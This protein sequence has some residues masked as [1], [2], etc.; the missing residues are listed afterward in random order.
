MNEHTPENDATLTER[1]REGLIEAIQ[2]G[3]EVEFVESLIATRLARFI[4]PGLTDH[5]V[6]RGQSS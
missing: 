3:N 2:A 4:P 1:E 5:V 6:P